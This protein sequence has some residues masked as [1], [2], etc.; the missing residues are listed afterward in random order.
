MPGGRR[1]DGSGVWSFLFGSFGGIGRLEAGWRGDV[2]QG[3]A[4][5][6]GLIGLATGFVAFIISGTDAWLS[7]TVRLLVPLAAGLL[8]GSIGL[9]AV[10]PW[11]L[12]VA[13]VAGLCAGVAMVGVDLARPSVMLIVGVLCLLSVVA[14]V[15]ARRV[16][17][18]G[19]MGPLDLGALGT[20]LGALVF[21]I[22]VDPLPPPPT[23]ELAVDGTRSWTSADERAAS[24][25][26]VML[27]PGF[28][29]PIQVSDVT[30]LSSS[31]GRNPSTCSR[32]RPA[33]S[34]SGG[35]FPTAARGTSL[36]G[37][38]TIRTGPTVRASTG[39]PGDGGTAS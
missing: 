2:V 15:A 5:E 1:D 23:L 22:A 17:R 10:R 8:V 21:A 38:L 39:R 25:D 4:V 36:S 12:P 19:A 7:S 37:R 6:Y 27:V 35:G 3:V 32:F 26:Q 14:L 31:R 24:D 29:Q 9:V 33:T 11:A 18:P 34:S 16:F 13:I 28:A 20:V 30:A